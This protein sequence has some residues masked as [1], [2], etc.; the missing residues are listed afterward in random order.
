MLYYLLHYTY[1]SISLHILHC[2]AEC[3][4]CS[5]GIYPSIYCFLYILMVF[6]LSFLLPLCWSVYIYMSYIY[7]YKY[8]ILY[9]DT[10]YLCYYVSVLNH[11]IHSIH[12][13]RSMYLH[14]HVS[15]ALWGLFLCGSISLNSLL[16]LSVSVSFR[17]LF[18]ETLLIHHSIYVAPSSV[19]ISI[20]IA[21]T[22]S[23]F[24]LLVYFSIWLFP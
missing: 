16:C 3:I 19:Y 24:D 17:I 2:V 10:Q 12:L 20:P 1:L 8:N 11:L 14:I 18:P 9:C 4:C 21:F 22:M 23:I 5:F 13:Y 7:I 15:D 6:S